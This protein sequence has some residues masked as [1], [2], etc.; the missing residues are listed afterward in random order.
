MIDFKESIQA[1]VEALLSP[2]FA[3]RLAGWRPKGRV[4]I[5]SKGSLLAECLLAQGRSVFALLRPSTDWI[6]PTHFM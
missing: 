5:E 2:N 4:A 6:R 1:V 3:G